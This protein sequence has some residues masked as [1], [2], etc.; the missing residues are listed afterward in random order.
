MVKINCKA[1]FEDMDFQTIKLEKG[2]N[3]EGIL[4]ELIE[5]STGKVKKRVYADPSKFMSNGQSYL[6]F[7]YFERN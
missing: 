1:I 7:E 3:K 2:N 5:G 6:W 4:I